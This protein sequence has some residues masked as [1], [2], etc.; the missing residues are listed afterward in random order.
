MLNFMDQPG[1]VKKRLTFF[2][3]GIF[4]ISWTNVLE[5]VKQNL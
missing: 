4:N 2:Y 3:F 1:T 5:S